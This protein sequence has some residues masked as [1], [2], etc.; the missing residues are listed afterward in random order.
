MNFKTVTEYFHSATNLSIFAF[1]LQNE[2]LYLAKIPVA[3]TLPNKLKTKLQ[4][5]VYT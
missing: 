5:T 2:E 4:N 1:N 3:P